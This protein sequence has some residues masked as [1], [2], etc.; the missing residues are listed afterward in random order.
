MRLDAD[1]VVSIG[2]VDGAIELAGARAFCD[3]K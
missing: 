1:D 2:V 3:Q